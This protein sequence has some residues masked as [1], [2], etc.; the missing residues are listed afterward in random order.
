LL[1]V[2]KSE[3]QHTNFNCSPVC[4]EGS[5]VRQEGEYVNRKSFNAKQALYLSGVFWWQLQEQAK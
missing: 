4:P 5:W 1:I 3:L 2:D